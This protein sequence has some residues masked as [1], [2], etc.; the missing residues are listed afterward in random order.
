[1]APYKAP[2]QKAV[3]AVEAKL[4]LARFIQA[5]DLLHAISTDLAQDCLEDPIGFAEREK[6]GF[7]RIGKGVRDKLIKFCEQ[8]RS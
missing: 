8:T 2:T 3:K 5:R 6:E 1:M 4:L 7:Y